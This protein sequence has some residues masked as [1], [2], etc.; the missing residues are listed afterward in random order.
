VENR[1]RKKDRWGLKGEERTEAM[2]K[3][4]KKGD[5]MEKERKPD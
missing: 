1:N 3:R 2:R 5:K 4:I